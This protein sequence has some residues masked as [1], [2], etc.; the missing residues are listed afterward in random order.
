MAQ[1]SIVEEAEALLEMGAE[2]VDAATVRGL[3]DELAAMVGRN[4]QRR[5]LWRCGGAVGRMASNVSALRTASNAGGVMAD[6]KFCSVY[7]AQLKLDAERVYLLE[8]RLSNVKAERDRLHDELADARKRLDVG[9]VPREVHE[10]GWQWRPIDGD[11]AYAP[12]FGTI[13]A[14]RVCGCLVAGGPTACV[15]CVAHESEVGDD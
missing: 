9:G 13:R 3:L 4:P 14:C 8:R 11:T 6:C 2:M 10:R 12:P 5:Y 7:H 1:R 15:R